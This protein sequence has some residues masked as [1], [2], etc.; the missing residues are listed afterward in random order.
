MEEPVYALCFV[1][2]DSIGFFSRTFFSADVKTGE[3][4]GEWIIAFYFFI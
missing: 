1:E 4:Y 2:D 3:A